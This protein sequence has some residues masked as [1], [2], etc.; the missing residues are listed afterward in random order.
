[1]EEASK[2]KLTNLGEWL[3]QRARRYASTT[4]IVAEFFGLRENV[5]EPAIDDLIPQIDAVVPVTVEAE[6]LQA[7]SGGDWSM[8]GIRYVVRLGLASVGDPVRCEIAFTA[9]VDDECIRVRAAPG[10][11]PRVGGH[12]V[13]LP[14]R[15]ITVGTVQRAFRDLLVECLADRGA[16][17]H[18]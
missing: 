13:D 15:E 10:A 16:S 2:K 1:M 18:I 17:L 11:L 8:V 7:L 14:P 5:I 6:Y 9:S 3:A 12:E 4:N